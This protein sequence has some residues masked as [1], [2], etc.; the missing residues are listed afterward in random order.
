MNS[1]IALQL[2][3]EWSRMFGW[4]PPDWRH[5]I[6]GL[7]CQAVQQPHPPGVTHQQDI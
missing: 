3:K 2:D 7:T 4:Y 5:W 1:G 6:G